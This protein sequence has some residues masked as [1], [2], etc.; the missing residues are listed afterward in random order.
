MTTLWNVVFV[1]LK[2]T[3]CAMLR[4]EIPDTYIC[5]F[6]LDTERNILL[7]LGIDEISTL[8]HGGYFTTILSNSRIVEKWS[9]R[10]FMVEER[11]GAE[12]FRF[13]SRG[14]A[15]ETRLKKW[16]NRVGALWLRIYG[17]NKQQNGKN[18]RFTYFLI[19]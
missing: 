8:I 10:F 6:L 19:S 16:L 2:R 15:L 5:C 3:N 18:G 14:E 1:M 9:F 13:F 11:H 7:R 12:A 4:P 17:N